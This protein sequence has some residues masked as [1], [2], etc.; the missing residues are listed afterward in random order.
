MTMTRTNHDEG[1][2]VAE[3]TPCSQLGHNWTRTNHDEDEDEP[4]R[5]RDRTILQHQQQ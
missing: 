5:G 2:Y 3:G 1:E 4:G